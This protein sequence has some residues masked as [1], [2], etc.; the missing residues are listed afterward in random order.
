MPRHHWITAAAAL[1]AATALGLAPAASAG[2]VPVWDG[3]YA[4]TFFVDQKTGTSV[5]A[6]QTES[7]YTDNYTFDTSCTGG[8]CVATIVGGPAP[9]NASVPVPVTFTWNGSAWASK[10]NFHWNCLL[11]N[12]SIQWN[13]ATAEVS[14]TPQS[15][16]TLTGRWHTDIQSGTCQGT[17][18]ITMEAAPA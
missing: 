18:D 1:G 13:P 16:G 9:R 17:V 15:D 3:P 4:V 10:T 12:G 5:A 8:S 14:Y 2:G 6:S 7:R 11:S